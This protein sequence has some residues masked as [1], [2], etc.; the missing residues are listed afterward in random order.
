MTHNATS[1]LPA[2]LY[3]LLPPKAAHERH[4]SGR[5]VEMFER[6]GY[7]QVSPPLMEFEAS[8]LA[9][10]GAAALSSQ[11]YRV[12]DPQS[13]QMMGF[14]PDITL[15]VGRIAATRMAEWPRPLRLSYS[16]STL[17]MKGEGKERARQWRQAGIELIG[18]QDPAADAEVIAVA[19]QAIADLGGHDL[20]VDLNFP[21]LVWLVLEASDIPP[22][23][24]AEIQHAVECK[25]AGWVANAG[26]N[27]YAGAL[28]ALMDAAG[29]AEEGMRA[30]KA[31]D[32]PKPAR[33]QVDY[34]QAVID[35]L[36]E[37]KVPVELTI[38]PVENKGFEYHSLVSFSL[39]S[40]SAQSELGRG[41][42]Y[43]IAGEKADEPATGVTLYV[44]TLMEAVPQQAVANSVLVDA[45][46]SAVE[47][48]AWHEAGFVTVRALD[49]EVSAK[50][51]HR[52]GCTHVMEDGK[53]K[54]VMEAEREGK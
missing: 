40:R 18:V 39:F 49:G 14:R 44:N 25:D 5:L 1:L 22:G 21:G 11:T 28:V 9:G 36:A 27:G 34:V 4:V 3:D 51:A 12:M 50:A 31:I 23:Q 6:F 53:P 2:G 47:Y 54:A 10:R 15:Q 13:Q 33:Q 16:G 37:W 38:D 45:G 42:R 41:G 46:L 20:V 32:L 19:V 17:R 43:A 52:M 26:L 48:A 35:R 8:L 30:L 7:A 24:Y 29:S